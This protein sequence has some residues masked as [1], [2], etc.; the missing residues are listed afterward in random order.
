MLEAIL[1]F[2]GRL[3]WFSIT[4]LLGYWT[5]RATIRALSLGSLEVSEYGYYNQRPFKLFWRRGRQLIVSF[6]VAI[7]VG[8]FLWFGAYFGTVVYLSRG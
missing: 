5:G 3:I 7:G 2:F 6:M 4:Q 8:Q 1:G